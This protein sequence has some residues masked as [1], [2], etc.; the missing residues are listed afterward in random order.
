MFRFYHWPQQLPEQVWD[1]PLLM[2]LWWAWPYVM[3][4]PSW[5]VL[6]IICINIMHFRSIL[7][8]VLSFKRLYREYNVILYYI[9]SI[10][11]LNMTRIRNIWV[12]INDEGCV[13]IGDITVIGK[14]IT[15]HH[16]CVSDITKHHCAKSY[17][18]KKG[19]PMESVAP[20]DI[21]NHNLKNLV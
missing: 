4:M 3:E 11:Y 2:E 5:V 19:N 18:N 15:I 16:R 8:C 13:L 21:I 14:Y 7:H 20:G 1:W 17:F 9:I 6:F 10:K 12:Y